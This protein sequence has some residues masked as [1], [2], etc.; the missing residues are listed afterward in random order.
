MRTDGVDAGTRVDFETGVEAGIGYIGEHWSGWNW[1][2]CRYCREGSRCRLM[3][4]LVLKWMEWMQVWSD[5]GAGVDTRAGGA[6][7]MVSKVILL[8][9]G[10]SFKPS[11]CFVGSLAEVFA[12]PACGNV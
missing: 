6:P 2:G 1:S 5:A 7:P 10:L 9:D 3:L 12:I 11:L 8:D 4:M